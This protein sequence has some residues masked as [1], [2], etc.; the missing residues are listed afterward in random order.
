MENEFVARTIENMKREATSCRSC[1]YLNPYV[2]L[3]LR[4]A[5]VTSWLVTARW[6]TSMAYKA[7]A[8]DG[9][10]VTVTGLIVFRRDQATLLWSPY[11]N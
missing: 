6:R 8:I 11:N 9:A 4:A 7:L 2:G 1:E 5:A 10:S 3:R